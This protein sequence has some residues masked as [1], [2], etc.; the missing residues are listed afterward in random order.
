M[1]SEELINKTITLINQ[2]ETK[3]KELAI[4]KKNNFLI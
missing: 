3:Y 1:I 4:I 2:Y